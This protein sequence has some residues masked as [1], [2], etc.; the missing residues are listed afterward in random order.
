MFQIPK[1]W[2]RYLIQYKRDINEN[3]VEKSP[4]HGKESKGQINPIF[5]RLALSST[6]CTV[7]SCWDNKINLLKSWQM[8]VSIIAR[9]NIYVL[10]TMVKMYVSF[11][12][13][14]EKYL[15]FFF[16][17]TN[18]ILAKFLYPFIIRGR[19]DLQLVQKI[20]QKKCKSYD[21]DID[22]SN[23]HA[24]DMIINLNVHKDDQSTDWMILFKY[25]VEVR[26]TSW[27]GIS[28][29][30]PVGQIQP[31]KIKSVK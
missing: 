6:G 31:A 25:L 16:F 11:I 19:C 28:N 17:L 10:I 12:S 2:S 1:F 27:E 5:E 14:T 20:L 22:N 8:L 15:K 7:S 13:K 23:C 18:F 3:I 9:I 26:S 4:D 30:Q 21:F 24:N 29:Q